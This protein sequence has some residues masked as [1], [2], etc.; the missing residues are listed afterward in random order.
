MGGWDCVLGSVVLRARGSLRH[1]LP[2]Y[3]AA[4]K[5]RGKTVG[6]R[7]PRFPGYIFLQ[8]DI[9][10][11]RQVYNTVFVANRL[12]VPEQE[13]SA[14]ELGEI[15]QALETGLEIWLAPAIGKGVRV[16]I[17]RGPLRGWKA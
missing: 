6:F 9:Q 7:K 8:L 11:R 4:H 17:K 14:V 2:V 10:Q 5:Y 13:P 1:F 15:L 3:P 12:H 16:E